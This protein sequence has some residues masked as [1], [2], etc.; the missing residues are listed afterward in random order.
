ME[1]IPRNVERV[2]EVMALSSGYTAAMMFYRN[3]RE[4]TK[5][6]L[7]KGLGRIAEVPRDIDVDTDQLQRDLQQLLRWRTSRS[8]S[9]NLARVTGGRSCGYLEENDL[10]NSIM[11]WEC[12]WLKGPGK[13]VARL[14][15]VGPPLSPPE[16]PGGGVPS[17]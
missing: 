8:L 12:S 5:K 7:W 15:T 9:D 10:T 11:E 1:C 6:Q 4:L 14:W 17:L 13:N 16:V 2:D 3:A